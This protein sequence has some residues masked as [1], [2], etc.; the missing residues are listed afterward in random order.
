MN[1]FTCILQVLH[2]N[3]KLTLSILLPIIPLGLVPP[4][5]L[6]IIILTL[7]TE[8]DFPGATQLFLNATFTSKSNEH[9]HLYHIL[10]FS[11]VVLK[12]RFKKLHSHDQSLRNKKLSNMKTL[13][14]QLFNGYLSI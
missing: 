3:S 13:S 6:A 7:K 11:F 10:S 5:H 8:A 14:P 9:I 2:F 1:I 12:L 4:V